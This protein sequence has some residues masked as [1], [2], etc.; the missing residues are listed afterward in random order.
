MAGM[1]QIDHIIHMGL[2]SER[3]R[4]RFD[5]LCHVYRKART[6]P[7]L[8]PHFDQNRIVWSDEYSGL[9]A[10]PVYHEQFELQWKIAL[11]DKEYFDNPGTSTDDRYIEDRVYEW[12]GKH[13]SSAKGFHDATMGC[14]I[15][16]RRLDSALI[17]GKRCIDVGCGMG[18][19]T[20]A[21]QY[22]GAVDVLSVDISESALTSTARYNPRVLKADILQFPETHPELGGQFDFAN[23]W[24]VAMCTHDPPKAFASAAFTV[25]PGGALYLM[26]YAPEG[27]H[28]LL[29][30]NIARRKF[31]TL[32]TVEQKLA[33]VE[34]VWN[35]QWDWD[36]PLLHNLKNVA[37]NILGRPKGHKIGVLD[38]LEPFYNWVIPLGVIEVWMKDNGFGEM[39]VLNRHEKRKCAY[40]VVGIKRV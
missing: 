40:H 28:N 34:M 4:I 2:D 5:R 39:T 33:F 17:R 20:R 38:M 36:Y 24:G 18:R 9:Y 21:M 6:N 32:Q 37:G 19:W 3:A 13:P 30:T 27:M 11:E 7:M 1:A 22:I 10:P 14:R 29:S 31:H 8:N 15:L 26:V 35:R 25:K 16:D 23:V 12:T